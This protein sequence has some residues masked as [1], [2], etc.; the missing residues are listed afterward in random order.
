MT[1][2]TLDLQ[3]APDYPTFEECQGLPLFQKIESAIASIAKLLRAG[4][5]VLVGS[6]TGKDSSVLTNL[7]FAA[8][9]RVK[10][11]GLRVPDIVICVGDT[12]IDNPEVARH[13]KGEIQAMRQYAET[14][15]L[16]IHVQRITPS[17]TDK[18][19]LNLIGGRMMACVS[20][21]DAICSMM[22][23]VNP[24]TQFKKQF[25]SEYKSQRPVTLIGTRFAESASRG[26]AM[27]ERGE[28]PFEPMVN[29]Q[30]EWM[31]SPIAYWSDDDVFTYIGNV[32]N[33]RTE[34]F[35]DFKSLTKL[36]RSAMGACMVVA[37]ATGRASSTGCGARTGCF[38]CL[39]SKDD[40][41][42]ENMLTD[43]DHD[44]SY[45]EPLNHFRNWLRQEHY[46]PENR[47]YMPRSV[48]KNGTLKLTAYAYA[49]DMQLAMLRHLLTIQAVEFEEA[50]Q[51]GIAPRFELIDMRG[52]VALDYMF[53]R[54]GYQKPFA[55]LNEWEAIMVS[56][57]RY[58]LPDLDPETESPVD[59]RVLTVQIDPAQFQSSAM[60]PL[61]MAAV[62]SD[63]HCSELF[64]T[65]SRY[66]VDEEGAELFEF[67]ELDRAL[68]I[69]D[70]ENAR[71][72]AAVEKLVGMG[73][74][75]L[76]HSSRNKLDA[77]IGLSD[78]IH[79]NKLR[80]LLNQPE[81][82]AAAIQSI[83]KA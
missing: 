74:V 35:S 11:E 51:L 72:A 75:Q 76:H 62:D 24:I 8:G 6:S 69:H 30:G 82:L 22:L 65:A 33:G 16:P 52:I 10:R 55:A 78:F 43:E 48:G 81:Q 18:Y 49:P 7:T 12:E 38:A 26:E 53:G 40:R 2:L 58:P 57:Q 47:N 17:M 46:K 73:V 83:G 34:C 5:P 66:D 80:D 28:N 36:Y 54:Y 44:L 59:R 42:M 4:Q 1:S 70:S 19:L 41:S 56:G 21:A 77:S 13:A 60:S 25:F 3:I 61:Y 39:R 50:R 23:K 67:F 79:R 15:E 37:F 45:M 63:N 20:E 32:T 9:L 27:A 71:P 64:D 31:M 68:A 29:P 14:K